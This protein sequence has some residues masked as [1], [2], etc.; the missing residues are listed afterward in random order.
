LET[1]N[2]PHLY[3]LCIE[4]FVAKNTHRTG[5]KFEEF[6]VK[7]TIFC[8]LLFQEYELLVLQQLQWEISSVTPLDFL[9]HILTRLGLDQDWSENQLDELKLRMETVLALAVTEYTFSYLSPSLLAA[10][11]IQLVLSKF[12]TFNEDKIDQKLVKITSAISVS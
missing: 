1:E 10:S 5:L 12:T 2:S 6:F 11:A 9:D 3:F 7:L 4:V 8:H